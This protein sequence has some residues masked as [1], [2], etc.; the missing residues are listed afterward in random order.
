MPTLRALPDRPNLEHVR[1]EA[2]SLLRQLKSANRAALERAAAVHAHLRTKEATRVQLADAQLVIAREYGFSSWPR[3]VHYFRDVERQQHAN[4]Q[5][6]G[7]RNQ[8]EAAARGLIAQH[9]RQ[10]SWAGRAL[11][12][13]VPRFFGLG[14]QDVFAHNVTEEEARLAVA[15]M[16]GAP[17]WSVLL[18]RL[19]GNARAE[20]GP[21]EVDPMDAAIEAI[22]K[23][24]VNALQ[25]VIAAHPA[26]LQPS[27]FDINTGRTLMGVALGAEWNLGVEATRPIM[28]WL[29]ARGFDRQRVL[30]DRLCGHIRMTVDEVQRLLH[31]GA[32]PNWVAPN[33]IPVLEHALLRYWSGDAVDALAARTTPR[34][35]LW[36]AAGLGNVDGVRGFLDRNG[37][38][39]TE[40]RRL[41]PDF[42]AVGASGFMPALPEADH[43]ELLLETL[44]VALLNGRTSVIEYMA[45]R[46]APINSM[47][48]G[49]SLVHIAV[50]NGMTDVVECLLHCGA[51]LDLRGSSPEMTT[52]EL[53]RYMIEQSPGNAKYRRIAELC[54]I[55]PTAVL[56]TPARPPGIDHALQQA[57]ALAQDDAARQQQ[58]AVDPVN[59][60]IGLLRAGGPPLYFLKGVGRMNVDAF[61]VDFAKRLAPESEAVVQWDL[62]MDA[63]A[64]EALRAAIDFAAQHRREEVYGLHLLRA[65]TQ[66][67]NGQVGQLLRI[68][69][70]DVTHVTAQLD[71]SI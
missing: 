19:D 47:I 68:Y 71:H 1:K 57:L 44:L 55:D 13:Y 17:S 24:D 38:P 16:H 21:W 4:R 22:K 64:Q 29:E 3:L 30:N 62:P 10:G 18:E 20:P 58:P 46:G 48:Y 66:D 65:L 49:S 12:A 59:L 2:K 40:A 67:Q 27:H 39:T 50:G 42:V 14:I 53:A 61:R 25:T 51:D 9:A 28:D 26:L 6:H 37:H 23:A 63:S 56:A 52:R 8:V 32:D 31:Q 43:E 35:A 5:F 34:K 36:I 11:A 70:V 15:R 69:G 54:G 7:G 45:A 60:L 33:G 41:R